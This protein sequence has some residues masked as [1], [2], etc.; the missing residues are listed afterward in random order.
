MTELSQKPLEEL[1]SAYIDNNI[2]VILWGTL[3]MTSQCTYSS[4]KTPDGKTIQYNN[5]LHCLL[6]VGYDE[7]YYYFNDPLRDVGGQK[8][9]GY[10]ERGQ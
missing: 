2:P 7:N 8:Y 4:W 10:A 1:C 6:L 5:K 9:V 3:K